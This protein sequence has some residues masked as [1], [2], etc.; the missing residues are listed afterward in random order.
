MP[1]HPHQSPEV[2]RATVQ[3]LRDLVE[4]HD[5]VCMLTDSRESRWLPSLLVAAA[6]RKRVPAT[7]GS[8][9]AEG[10]SPP[11]RSEARPPLGMT[12]ALGFDSFLVQRQTYL[13]SPA[14]CYF[15]NDVTAPRDSLAFRTLDQQCTVT[16]PGLS[17][18]SAGIAVELVA[19]LV[20]H[21]DRFEAK[22]SGKPSCLGCVPHQ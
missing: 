1:G 15:C 13:E 22:H 6:Q 17:G 14:A 11:S 9:A 5:V 4:S 8:E 21:E 19:A 12:V 20:Q 18:I 2:L 3:K 7:T 16:R 10:F